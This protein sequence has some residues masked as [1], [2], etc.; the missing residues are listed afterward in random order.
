MQSKV[1]SL[2]QLFSSSLRQSSGE[3]WSGA[4]RLFDTGPL[5]SNSLSHSTTSPNS[6]HVSPTSQDGREALSFFQRHMSPVFPFVVIPSDTGPDTLARE[7]PVLWMALMLVARWQD[8]STRSALS[9]AFREEVGRRILAHDE[10][11]LDLLQ[12]I[13]VYTA[14]YAE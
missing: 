6:P 12:S 3:H 2:E 5:N 13:L 14:W 11:T 8:E 1:E 10:R 9:T 7:K 4:Q